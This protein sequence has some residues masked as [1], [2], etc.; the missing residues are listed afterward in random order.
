MHNAGSNTSIENIKLLLNKTNYDSIYI[1]M[2]SRQC[3]TATV[4]D[5]LDKTL[6]SLEVIE[7]LCEKES[8]NLF[9]GGPATKLVDQNIKLKYT[10]FSKFSEIINF[11]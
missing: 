6:K 1:Y 9:I 11:V 7:S 5:H 2:C 4:R 10:K 8:I 3:C